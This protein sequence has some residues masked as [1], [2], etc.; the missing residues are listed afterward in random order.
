MEG[1]HTGLVREARPG[2]ERALH[3][4]ICALEEREFP[5]EPFC[6]RLRAQAADGRHTCLVYEDAGD[7]GR[8]VG[9]L[10]MRIEPQLHHELPTAE[11]LELVVDASQRGR[12]VGAL[13]F[14][15]ARERA[16]EAGCEQLELASNARRVDAHR[17][18]E[19]EGMDKSHVHFT[20]PLSPTVR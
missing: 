6:T 11:I 10:N 19:R 7:A 12:G 8:V 3:A 16:S 4:L 5:F 20:M 9:M 15:A 17:F 13:L 2:D 18:Y 1:Q 14:A